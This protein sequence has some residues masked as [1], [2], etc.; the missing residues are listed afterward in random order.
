MCYL[1]WVSDRWQNFLKC[2]YPVNGRTVARTQVSGFLVQ[3]SSSKHCFIISNSVNLKLL[4]SHSVMSDFTPHGLQHS[5][6]PCPS[7]SPS[8]CS[9]SCPLSQWWIRPRSFSEGDH[10][11]KLRSLWNKQGG[12]LR[13]RPSGYHGQGSMVQQKPRRRLEPASMYPMRELKN[14]SGSWVSSVTNMSTVGQWGIQ[15]PGNEEK[16]LH[17]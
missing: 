9:N 6:L 4:F 8:A 14:F 1:Y 10:C 2:T 7:P 11:H 17:I 15:Q 3:S 12:L 16:L 13:T 5:R